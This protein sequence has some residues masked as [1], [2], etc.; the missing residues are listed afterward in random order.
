MILHIPHSSRNVP[1]ALRVQITLDDAAL[2]VELTRM[3]DAY[4]DELFVFPGATYVVFPI[5]RLVVDVER[6]IEDKDEP[7]AAAG[8]GVI[9]TL[10]SQGLPM[11]RPLSDRA[12][13]RLISD[14][15]APHHRRLEEAVRSELDAHGHALL[16]D[17]HSFPSKP[18]PCDRDQSEPRPDFC[19]GTSNY[20]TPA[21]LREAARES[22]VRHGL[23]VFE[24]KPYADCLV[25]LIFCQKNRDVHAIMIEVN[26]RLY[27]DENSGERSGKFGAIAQVIRRILRELDELDHQ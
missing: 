4:T 1:A 8:M 15:Y 12:R 14:Y 18:L 7:M 3:T 21:K 27:M 26:R 6:F 17:C 11:R 9:Y 19:I 23:S 20:H 13:E 24:N 25:P 5:S 16:V 10:T 2:D 22:I